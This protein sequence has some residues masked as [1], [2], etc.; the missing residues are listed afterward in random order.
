[1]KRP[2]YQFY[3]G[4]WLQEV[5]LRACTLAARG[6]WIDMNCLMHQGHPYGHLTFPA[7]DGAKDVPCP[8][9][10][11]YLARM[12]G[13][14]VEE[15][16]SLLT[17]L[18]DAGV[19]SRTPEG[20][21][22]CRRMPRDEILRDLRAN[23]GKKSLENPNVPRPKPRK[24]LEPIPKSLPSGISLTGSPSSSSSSSSS[25]DEDVTTASM[26]ARILSEK[27]GTPNLQFQKQLSRQ[28]ATV[29]HKFG[30][31]PLQAVDRMESQWLSYNVA[32]PS[33]S[34]TVSSAQ[35]FFESGIWQEESL[36]PWKDGRKPQQV[37][38]NRYFR[39]NA[40]A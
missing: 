5:S 39:G 26:A 23:W 7:K 25:K 30:E 1:M 4:D 21:I 8:I 6:L 20:V 13:T 9:L 2:S 15:V 28:L 34:Y 12:V 31:T 38:P 3:P 32:R 16:T 40:H 18:E 35:K 33:L 36:W 10:P 27:L 24:A 19:F 11:E 17:E 22:F 37:N 14:T 29:A